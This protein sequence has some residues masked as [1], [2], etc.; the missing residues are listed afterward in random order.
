MV[1]RPQGQTRLRL[2]VAATNIK[3]ALRELAKKQGIPQEAVAQV[4]QAPK[5]F[6]TYQS[7]VAVLAQAIHRPLSSLPNPLGKQPPRKAKARVLPPGSFSFPWLSPSYSTA[8]PVCRLVTRMGWFAL[9]SIRFPEMAASALCQL[10]PSVPNPS[11]A[12][13]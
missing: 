6:L 1:A 9:L 12:K 5:V 3:L 7:C 11:S 2:R 13:R 8:P 10:S 4:A